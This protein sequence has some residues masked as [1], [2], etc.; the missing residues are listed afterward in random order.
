MKTN[1]SLDVMEKLN[2]ATIQHG[3]FNNRIYLMQFGQ[4]KPDELAQSLIDM[5]R[6]KKY[7]KIFAKVPRSKSKPFVDLG[8]IQESVIPNYFHGTED[9]LFMAYYLDTQRAHAINQD[10]ISSIISIA[11]HKA[12]SVTTSPKKLPSDC[13]LRKCTLDDLDA[14]AEVYKQVFA[15][16]P[17]PIHDLDYLAQTM[18]THIDYYGIW[19][20]GNLVALASSEIS[21][22][23]STVEMTDFATLPEFRGFGFAQQLL[24]IME[25]DMREIGIKT[26]YTI[27]R[28]RS[29]GMNITFAR[30]GYHFAGTLI[31][32]TNISGAIESMNIW[33]KPL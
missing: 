12:K 27:A 21:R 25:S 17:F 29:A 14:M 15:T 18:R 22:T 19:K 32:N 28:A 4:E 9:A 13:V 6:D 3:R 16:Y 1:D 24:R 2:T 31:N 33:Y 8:Y 20:D 5:A 30:N 10:E 23:Y 11:Q 26:A 7:T